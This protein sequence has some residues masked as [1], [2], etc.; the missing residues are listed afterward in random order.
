MQKF[1]DQ[2]EKFGAIF[3]QGEIDSVSKDS[4]GFFVELG[5]KVIHGKSLIIA[6]GTEHKKLNIK[7]EK[8]FLGKGVSYC[9]T[10]DAMFFKNK[11]VVVIGGA[12]SAAKAA[13]YLSDLAKEVSIVYRKTQMRCEPVSLKKIEKTPNIK[14]YYNSNPV[15]IIGDKKVRGLKISQ[16]VNGKIGESLIETDGVF[17]EVGATP[18]TD[19]VKNIN[20]DLCDGYIKTDKNMKTS[21]EGVF[22]AGDNTNNNFK[23]IVVSSGEGAVA[24]KSAYDYIKS[25]N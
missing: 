16:E 23:Q 8:E 10:C 19:V 7:G 9:A 4:D 15:E 18:M 6:L 24:A 13:L 5:D 1:K 14:I 17:I 11:K 3:H 21:V 25:L 20:L 22:G 2:A 12:N